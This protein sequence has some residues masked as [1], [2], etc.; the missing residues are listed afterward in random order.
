MIDK[1]VMMLKKDILG[2]N[3]KVNG[4]EMDVEDEF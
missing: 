2:V 3:G 1:E 4:D